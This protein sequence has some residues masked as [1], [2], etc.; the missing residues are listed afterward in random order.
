V[1][2]G[3]L[4]DILNLKKGGERN[5]MRSLFIR[6]VIVVA[7]VISATNVIVFYHYAYV[8]NSEK[9]SIF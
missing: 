9:R 1:W 2:L 5:I 4:R 7:I 8:I 3:I 6:F